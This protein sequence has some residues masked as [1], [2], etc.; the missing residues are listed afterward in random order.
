VQYLRTAMAIVAA[1]EGIG[2]SKVVSGESI[3]RH[4]SKRAFS[5]NSGNFFY[6]IE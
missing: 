3:Y 4:I 2:G 6:R 1:A 5:R